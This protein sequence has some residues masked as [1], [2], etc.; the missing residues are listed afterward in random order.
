MENQIELLDEIDSSVESTDNESQ[1]SMK[2]ILSD[3]RL[4]W[5]TLIA[6]VDTMVNQYNEI[7]SLLET[8]DRK[9]DDVGIWIQEVEG[10]QKHL[11][12][13]QNVDALVKTKEKLTVSLF[14]I[15]W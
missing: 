13:E 8:F 6:K 4:E 3:K 1:S 2:K 5:R 14:F 7:P 11:E 15:E 10:C 12:Q 9:Y